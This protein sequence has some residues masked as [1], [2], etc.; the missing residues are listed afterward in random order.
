MSQYTIRVAFSHTF[1]FNLDPMKEKLWHDI[2]ELR[3]RDP[4]NLALALRFAIC[5]P[6]DKHNGITSQP[7]R[8]SQMNLDEIPKPFHSL[9]GRQTIALE[10]TR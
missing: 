5:L 6:I 7:T 9:I 4:A 2:Q 3:G 1:K 10:T 8:S